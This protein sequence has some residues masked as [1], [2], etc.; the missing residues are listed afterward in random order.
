MHVATF[1]AK[2]LIFIFIGNADIS[3]EISCKYNEYILIGNVYNKK[4]EIKLVL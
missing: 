3:S 4:D 2:C 1:D